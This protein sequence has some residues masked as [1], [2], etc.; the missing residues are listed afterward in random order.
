MSRRIK[1]PVTI[2]CARPDCRRTFLYRGPSKKYCSLRCQG[3][4]ANRRHRKKYPPC[5]KIGICVCCFIVFESTRRGAKYC[6]SRCRSRINSRRER[7]QH[8]ERCAKY[9]KRWCK[10][11]PMRTKVQN[12]RADLKKHY[13]LT[14]EQK[15]ARIAA[16]DYRCAVCGTTEPGGRGAWCTDHDHKTGI[17][18]DELC[19]NCN[20]ALGMVKENP[21]VLQSLI[22]YL[23][24]WSL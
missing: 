12:K 10:Q 8:P 14:L 19:H 4:E 7:K 3:T 20:A 24:K 11:N 9:K 17:L 23:K 15:E 5:P 1:N 6:S 22:E 18:R 21:N 13:G 16:Q 2:G